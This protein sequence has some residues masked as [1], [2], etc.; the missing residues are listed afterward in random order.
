M[1]LVDENLSCL[2]HVLSVFV[3]SGGLSRDQYCDYSFLQ[4][5]VVNTQFSVSFSGGLTSSIQC[6]HT[7]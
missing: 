1:I 2:M 7:I 6:V 3:L 5:Y 4:I